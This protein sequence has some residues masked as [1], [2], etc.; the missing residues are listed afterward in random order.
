MWDNCKPYIGNE[1][2]KI[3]EEGAKI[4]GTFSAEKG[5]IDHAEC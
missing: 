1:E 5:A 4:L 3:E 2:E